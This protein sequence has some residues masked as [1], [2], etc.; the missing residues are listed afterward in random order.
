MMQRIGGKIKVIPNGRNTRTFAKAK[1]RLRLRI[2]TYENV[3][4]N[5]QLIDSADTK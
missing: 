5:K 4:K 1:I 3:G 2:E